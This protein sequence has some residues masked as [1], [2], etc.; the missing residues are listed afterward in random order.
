MYDWNTYPLP[1]GTET[2][3][4]VIESTSLTGYL[5]NGEWFAHTAVH[6]PRGVAEPLVVLA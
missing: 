3:H 2:Q 4:G 5:I 1:A 6:G